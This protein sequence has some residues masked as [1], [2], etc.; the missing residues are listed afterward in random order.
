VA[1]DLRAL[2]RPALGKA[3]GKGERADDHGEKA[4]A[5][6]EPAATREREDLL[7]RAAMDRFVWGSVRLG[8]GHPTYLFWKK[9]D[10][11]SRT[12]VGEMMLGFFWDAIG[13][14]T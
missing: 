14:S 11:I 1:D 8:G 2:R 6:A 4:K 10:D 3:E 13:F 9:C 7:V 5:E 12:H